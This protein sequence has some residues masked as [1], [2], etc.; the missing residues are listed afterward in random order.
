MRNGRRTC[1]CSCRV[2][3]GRYPQYEG[4]KMYGTRSRIEVTKVWGRQ[5]DGWKGRVGM[6]EAYYIRLVAARRQTTSQVTASLSGGRTE[7]V[8]RRWQPRY[9]SGVPSSRKLLAAPTAATRTYFTDIVQQT[10]T[11]AISRPVQFASRN[12][13]P[14]AF[15]LGRPES[16][17]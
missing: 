16:D 4:T 8:G 15:G 7:V 9:K 6:V 17:S 5:W 2:F 14:S 11:S 10:V 1:S 12:Y 13:T 3:H